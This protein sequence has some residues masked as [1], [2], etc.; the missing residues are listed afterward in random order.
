MLSIYLL[1]VEEESLLIWITP[2]KDRLEIIWENGGYA[3]LTKEIKNEERLEWSSFSSKRL[4]V[5][6]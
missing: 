5:L 1:Y 6:Y 4:M 3:L 2:K